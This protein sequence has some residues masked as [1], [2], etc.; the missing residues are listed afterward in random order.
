MLWV[1]T[2][3]AVCYSSLSVLW[4]HMRESRSLSL[5]SQVEKLLLWHKY[6]TLGAQVQRR[7]ENA[8]LLTLAKV[9]PEDPV[10]TQVHIAA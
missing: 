4:E 1:E 9:L 5:Y 2:D 7:E 10:P 8:A 6:L 3:L